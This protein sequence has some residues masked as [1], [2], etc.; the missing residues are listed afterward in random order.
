MNILTLYD[1]LTWFFYMMDLSVEVAGALLEQAMLEILH[2]VKYGSE[3]A[4]PLEVTIQAA[5]V[6]FV[7]P[8]CLWSF[9]AV[10][11]CIRGTVPLSWCR[12]VLLS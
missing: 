6:A 2:P 8:R 1:R 11:W 10:L 9:V 3:F 7:A 5:E 12:V 4:L